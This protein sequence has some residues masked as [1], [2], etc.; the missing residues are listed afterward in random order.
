M[1][2]ESRIH[3]CWH[4]DI[5]LILSLLLAV[6]LSCPCWRLA[7]VHA[8]LRAC[9]CVC[10]YVLPCSHILLMF[11][12]PGPISKNTPMPLWWWWVCP[13]GCCVSITLLSEGLQMHCGCSPDPLLN[14]KAAGGRSKVT[15]RASESDFSHSY[16]YLQREVWIL[17]LKHIRGWKS[18]P[19]A[20]VKS[21]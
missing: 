19:C 18:V 20:L 1:T 15:G 5:P 7:S 6:T 14:N 10:I 17:L 12:S 8:C 21:T 13:A 4:H 9:V 11:I 3:G 2:V 16:L